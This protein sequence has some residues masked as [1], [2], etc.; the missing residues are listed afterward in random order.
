MSVQRLIPAVMARKNTGGDSRLVG[1]LG[2]ILRATAWPS[3]KGTA[4]I[5]D[6]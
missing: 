2:G 5:V 4:E 6:A 1:R 3:L